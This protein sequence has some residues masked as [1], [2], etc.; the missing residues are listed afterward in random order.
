[1]FW[2]VGAASR[3][4]PN[5]QH[6]FRELNGFELLGSA[7]D[8]LRGDEDGVISSLNNKLRVKAATLV[9]DLSR[10]VMKHL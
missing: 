9:S 10:W 5:V 4:S 3:N 1:M 7:V 6:L 2:Q 8:R